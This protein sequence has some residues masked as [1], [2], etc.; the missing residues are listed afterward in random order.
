M[1]D[2]ID[3]KGIATISCDK[4]FDQGSKCKFKFT[5]GSE[6]KAKVDFEPTIQSLGSGP[7]Y[8]APA[9]KTIH[10]RGMK[11]GATDTW[12]LNCFLE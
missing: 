7:V 2:A 9:G 3:E 8:E 4:P 1:A 5:D 12:T 11:F 6:K 10:C